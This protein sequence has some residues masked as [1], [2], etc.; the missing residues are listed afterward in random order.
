MKNPNPSRLLM[1]CILLLSASL[2]RAQYIAVAD[3]NFGFWLS[4]HPNTSGCI[5]GSNATGWRLDTTC[6]TL[7]TI[8]SIDCRNAYIHDLTLLRYFPNVTSLN[9]YNNHLDSLPPLPAGLTYLDCGYTHITRLPALPVSLTYLR[10]YYNL[11]TTLPTLPAGLV[12]LDIGQTAVRDSITSLPVTLRYLDVRGAPIRHLPDTLPSLDT[13]Y[14]TSYAQVPYP[15]LPAS[16]RFLACDWAGLHVL[17]ALPDSLHVLYCGGDSLVSLPT[18]PAGLLLLDCSDNQ[19][20]SL[21]ALPAGLLSLISNR[22]QLSSLPTLPPSLLNLE[23]SSNLF[24]S[25]PALPGSLRGLSCDHNPIPVLPTLPSHL[26]YLYCNNTLITGLPAFPDSLVGISCNG[27]PALSCLPHIHQSRLNNFYID[28]TN[29]HCLPNRFTALNYDV[30][31]D[32]MALCTASSGCD[33]YYNIAGNIHNDTSGNCTLDSLS[34]GR[35]I[36]NMKVQL[37][38]SGVVVKQFYTF[39]SG[40]YSFKADSLTQYTVEIDTTMLPM[41]IACPASG[42]RAISLSATDSVATGQNFG[43]V[44]PS[45]PDYGVVWVYA[46]RFRPGLTTS[47]SITSGSLAG[48]RYGAI[49]GTGVSGTVT[50]IISGPVVYAGP[51]GSGLTPTSV[52]GDTLLYTIADLNIL[53]AGDLD[54]LV[55]TDST[56]TPGTDVCIT[57]IISPSVPDG[58]AVN[59]TQTQ[60]F[61]VRYSHDPNHKDGYPTIISPQGGW[62][63]YTIH[64]QN[65]GHDTAYAVVIRDTLSSYVDAATFQYIGSSHQPI[66]TLTGRAMEFGFPKINLVDSATNPPLSEGWIQYKVKAKANLPLLTQ[67]KNTA[68]IY[69]DNNAAIATNT[70]VNTV[71]TIAAPLAIARITDGGSIHLYPNPSTGTF[72]L[73]TSNCLHTDYVITDMLGSVVQQKTISSDGQAIDIRNVAEGVYTLAVRGKVIRFV[74]VR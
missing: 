39:T 72:T 61:Q 33:F 17:P 42:A 15:V 16:M 38:R 7:S 24:T 37:K 19:L 70:T 57:S 44:C 68:Y 9:C 43:M 8:T 54:I 48:L 64:F 47:V 6:S 10:I 35:P 2:S 21:P 3:T 1:L 12:H 31:P 11:I 34:P 28:S 58:H 29:I 65:T 25:V 32:T 41:S 14:A 60:C 67:V 53:P 69:F 5:A 56:A 36:Y 27:N 46:S 18:L 71:D 49:C 73:Q 4:Y 22:D 55:T 20:A 63:T 50:T 13:L 52:S 23:I 74:V 62:L 51:S 66:V 45:S 59:D 30:L 26:Q 40:D